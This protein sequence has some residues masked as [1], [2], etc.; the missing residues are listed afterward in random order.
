M[1]AHV[2][3]LMGAGCFAKGRAVP[4]GPSTAPDEELGPALRDDL[5]PSMRR[6]GRCVK[7]RLLC[8]T[9]YDIQE[10]STG[11]DGE[12]VLDRRVWSPSFPARK[13]VNLYTRLMTGHDEDL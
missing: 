7:S 11:K 8:N 9:V 1:L 12:G 13:A 5:F 3:T 4:V 10:R 6:E 2:C